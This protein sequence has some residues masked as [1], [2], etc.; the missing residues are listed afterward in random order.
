MFDL[1]GVACVGKASFFRHTSLYVHPVIIEE[2]RKQQALLFQKL[3]QMDGGLIL[4]GDGRCDSP[5]HTAKFGSYSVIE[6]RIRRVLDVQ[7]VQVSIHVRKSATN[8]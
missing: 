7:L 2:W 6:Q 8:I 3:Q 1:M 4:A 5:G